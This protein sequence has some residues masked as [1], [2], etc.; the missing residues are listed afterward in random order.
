MI[1]LKYVSNFWRSVETLLI[2]CE[3]NF[4]LTWSQNCV[5]VAIAVANKTAKFRI[6]DTKFYVPVVTL[7]TQ[8]NGKLL[9]NQKS[10]FKRKI[11]WNKNK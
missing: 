11:D 6:T 1:T 8:D 3:T 5:L 9:E 4:I 2:N 7:S 10:S